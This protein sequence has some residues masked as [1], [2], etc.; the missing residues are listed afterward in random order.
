[1]RMF[2]PFVIP[3][4]ALGAALVAATPGASG[5]PSGVPR[6]RTS[7]LVIWISAGQGAAGSVSYTLEFT[8]QSGSTCTL[9]GY[10]GVAALNL[11]GRQ[12][13]S[14][15]SRDTATKVRTIRLRNDASATSTVRIVDAL[16]FPASSCRPTDAAGVRVYPPN[17]RAVKDR[18]AA[19][20]GLHEEAGV[21]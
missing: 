3:F 14:A 8:N 11:R 7:G 1:M 6:C 17:E 2:K 13:G 20:E 9:R 10:P 18:A 16:N 15:A 21:Y 5:A 12:L 4:V 19:V